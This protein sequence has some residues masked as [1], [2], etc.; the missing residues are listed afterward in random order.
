MFACLFYIFTFFIVVKHNDWF[1]F[2]APLL[3][4]FNVCGK[5]NSDQVISK[6][7]VERMFGGMIEE[8][9]RGNFYGVFASII[10]QH[11]MIPSSKF[12]SWVSSRYQYDFLL[13]CAL[14]ATRCCSCKC[15]DADVLCCVHELREIREWE[16]EESSSFIKN[17]S[18]AVPARKWCSYQICFNKILEVPGSTT[19]WIQLVTPGVTWMLLMSKRSCYFVDVY[20][21]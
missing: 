9:I 4:F 13:G 5:K 14:N 12:P 18:E 10:L 6:R 21:L 17:L 11:K 15:C 8:R 19:S 16:K 1:T 7:K 20:K 2:H 3:V